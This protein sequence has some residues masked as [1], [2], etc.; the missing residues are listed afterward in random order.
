MIRGRS[1]GATVGAG[2]ALADASVVVLAL[3][4]ILTELDASVEAAAAVIGA[5]TLALA[6]ALPITIRYHRRNEST[7]AAALGML[8]FALA[9]AGCGLAGAIAP[10]IAMRAIQGAAAAVVLIGAFEVLR[11]GDPGSAGRRAWVAVAVF[12]AAI[13]PALGGALTQ[14]VDWRAIFLL[15]APV[16]AAAAVACRNLPRAA[17]AATGA[18]AADRA[19]AT[20]VA[21]CLGFLS[22]ALTGVLFL[23]V[24]LLIFGWGLSPLGAAAVVSVVRS[25]PWRGP[26]CPAITRCVRSSG[27]RSSGSACC[28][29]RSCR[30]TPWR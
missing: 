15:Q 11:A 22:A 14:L 7:R 4:P 8:G 5:Y 27:P 26:G 30:W 13:G 20:A 12:G 19:P 21:V 25:P 29:W 28:A 16:V 3:P 9:G 10:L 18:S 23:A 2:L 1:I 6:V 17:A 24:L